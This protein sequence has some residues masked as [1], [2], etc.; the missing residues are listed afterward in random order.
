MRLL[1][2]SDLHLHSEAVGAA[3]D[4]QH[5]LPFLTQIAASVAEV[6][7]D[8]RD[9]GPSFPRHRCACFRQHCA[10]KASLDP[11]PVLHRGTV[12]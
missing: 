5:L 2:L 9:G 10:S 11:M 6:S 8:A 12:L 7:P 1:C 3:I 4:R